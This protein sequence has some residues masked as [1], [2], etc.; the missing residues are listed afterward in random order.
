MKTMKKAAVIQALGQLQGAQS[1]GNVLVRELLLD[2]GMHEL[3]DLFNRNG[4]LR[5]SGEGDG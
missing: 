5:I 4:R 1:V 3:L 2:G